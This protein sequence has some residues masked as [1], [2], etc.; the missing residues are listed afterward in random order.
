ML[1]IMK[2]TRLAV[3]FSCLFI[4]S[5]KNENDGHSIELETYGFAKLDAAHQVLVKTEKD[6]IEFALVMSVDS[7]SEWLSRSPALYDSI[8]Y[9]MKEDMLTPS[10]IKNAVMSNGRIYVM[11]DAVQLQN[12]RYQMACT[13]ELPDGMAKLQNENCNQFENPTAKITITYLKY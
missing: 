5:C 1:I 4:F 9:D 12:G 11:D 10:Q 8:G 3:I 6:K 7:A 2:M 13:V